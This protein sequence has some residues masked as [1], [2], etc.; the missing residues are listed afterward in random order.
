MS[1]LFNP[2]GALSSSP[3]SLLSLPS[4][5]HPSLL[6]RDLSCPFGFPRSS[7][8]SNN[9]FICICIFDSFGRKIDSLCPLNHTILTPCLISRDILIQ[10][11]HCLILKDL[12]IYSGLLGRYLM[13]RV[14]DSVQP[15]RD[16]NVCHGYLPKELGISQLTSC[17]FLS[18]VFI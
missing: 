18:S 15:H 16:P 3:L 14:F 17:K 2:P 8:N 12:R 13:E 6:H 7:A 5:L 1:P 11:L 9:Y 4:F 10:T